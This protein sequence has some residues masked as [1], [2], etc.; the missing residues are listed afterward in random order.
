MDQTRYDTFVVIKYIETATTKE[1]SDFH[2]TTLPNDI[3]I[4]KEYASTTDKKVDMLYREY[5]IHYRAF[6]KILIHLL[7]AI[8]YLCFAVH[9]MTKFSS[10]PGKVHFEGLV[11][12][13]RYIGGKQTWY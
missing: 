2:K 13:L 11:H 10:N 7:S 5:N 12:L 1:N 6:V 9:K 8:L 3:L 4:T